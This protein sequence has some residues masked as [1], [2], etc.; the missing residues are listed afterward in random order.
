M[1]LFRTIFELEIAPESSLD[2]M[3]AGTIDGAFRGAVAFVSATIQAVD[4]PSGCP[5]VR[6][7]ER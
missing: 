5:S 4:V 3:F 1:K 2:V 6:G 7:G